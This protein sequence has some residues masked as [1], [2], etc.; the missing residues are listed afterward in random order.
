MQAGAIRNGSIYHATG[1]MRL[2]RDA[3]LRAL[4]ERVMDRPWLYSYT[5]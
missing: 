4:G 3:A 2:G 5:S 1:L